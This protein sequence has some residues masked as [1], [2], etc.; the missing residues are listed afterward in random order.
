MF[1]VKIKS[2]IPTSQC[3]TLHFPSPLAHSFPSLI[4]RSLPLMLRL[5]QSDGL[6]QHGGADWG[7]GS[8][9]VCGYYSKQNYS[10]Q[11]NLAQW[12]SPRSR[13]LMEIDKANLVLASS[14]RVLGIWKFHYNGFQILVPLT[15]WPDNFMLNAISTIT[16]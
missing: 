8:L 15:S 13:N 7:S 16:L 12:V 3:F 6:W 10:K 2:P 5:S 14:W 4:P 1:S 11:R 9:P